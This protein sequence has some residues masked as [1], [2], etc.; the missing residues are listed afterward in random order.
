M[1]KGVTLGSSRI[2][3]GGSEMKFRRNLPRV[4]VS[5]TNFTR[6]GVTFKPFG[7]SPQNY[8]FM[9]DFYRS[10]GG[11]YDA[12]VDSEMR[13]NRFMGANVQRLYLQL[14]EFIEGPNK[15]TLSVKATQMANLIKQV[16]MARENET[17]LLINGA[18]CWIP[19]D[20]PAW[21]DALGHEDRWDVQQYFWEQVVT[22]IVNSGNATTVLGYDLINEPI[23]DTNPAAEWSIPASNVVGAGIYYSCVI[24]RGPSVDGT[25]VQS[26]VTQLKT[27]IKAIDPAAL[28]TVGT[29]PYDIGYFGKDNLLGY[30]DFYSPHPYPPNATFATWTLANVLG[31]IAGWATASSPVLIGETLAWSNVVNGAED[32]M[33]A[34][35]ADMEGIISFSYGYPPSMYTSSPEPIRYPAEGSGS[36]W[37][38]SYQENKDALTLLLSYRDAFLA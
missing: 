4:S 28:V 15:T 33:D 1:S 37:G 3:I 21:Y 25:T 32:F 9:E 17:Y 6:N 26:W 13:G 27:A 34:V 30:V 8:Y 14:W 22:A 11:E 16:D 20:T 24:A 19:G 2:G 23:T 38:C 5:G 12:A 29:F 7:F 35:V 31:W 10:T 18:N 36:V